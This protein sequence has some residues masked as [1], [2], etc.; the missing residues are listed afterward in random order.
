[1]AGVDRSL[2][3][4]PFRN[5]INDGYVMTNAI[6]S[7]ETAAVRATATTCQRSIASGSARQRSA[8]FASTGRCGLT[9]FEVLISMAVATIGFFG[10]IVLIPV[11]TRQARVGLDTDAAAA[12]GRGA[13]EEFKIRGM[14]NPGNW[15]FWN[16]D[17]Q[18]NLYQLRPFQGT[19]GANDAICIDPEFLAA[20]I[21]DSPA[22]TR[23]F[24]F[25]NDKNVKAELPQNVPRMRRLSISLFPG[26]SSNLPRWQNG[27]VVN[28]RAMQAI[29]N[30]SQEIFTTSDD[31]V[32]DDRTDKTYP[33]VQQF[34][35]ESPDVV[36]NNNPP[37]LLKRASLGG[38]S[39]FAMITPKLS[40]NGQRISDEYLLS[41]VVVQRR[42]LLRDEFDR[43]ERVCGVVEFDGFSRIKTAYGGGELNLLAGTGW[44]DPSDLEVAENQWIMLSQRFVVPEVTG[45]GGP[46]APA[47][48]EEVL[49]NQYRWYRVTNVG[50][51]E[52]ISGTRRITVTG[53]DWIA[54]RDPQNPNNVNEVAATYATI[55]PGVVAVYEKSIQ[56]E[57]TSVWTRR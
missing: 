56:L 27:N 43:S 10:V 57:D 50:D 4:P 37:Q 15:M 38:L 51:V 44:G 19:L 34:A 7:L 24:P 46:T 39:W 16:Y 21:N 54:G 49:I 52:P 14:H 11:A 40:T 42:D 25:R 32:F 12:L 20:N 33:T 6:S 1:M 29:F 30:L 22:L 31:L 47:L 55:I 53:P 28:G 13:V 3:G 26:W 45:G 23:V 41:I 5:F 36:Q 8:R 9:I 18:A 2:N 48:K 35:V 17:N